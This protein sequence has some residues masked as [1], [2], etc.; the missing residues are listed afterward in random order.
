[1]ETEPPAK[2][3]ES[4][5]CNSGCNP[6]IL[7]VYEEQLKKYKREIKSSAASA[8]TANCIL[9]TRDSVDISVKYNEIVHTKKLEYDDIKTYLKDKYETTNVNVLICGSDN[10]MEDIKNL[11]LRCSM[12][13]ENGA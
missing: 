12:V 9:P 6:C 8:A 13:E 4:D 11:V 2:P 3:D 10:F 5:C 1:M 7:D